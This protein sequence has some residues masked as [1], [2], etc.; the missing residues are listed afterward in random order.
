MIIKYFVNVLYIM[1]KIKEE[2]IKLIVDTYYNVESGLSS[3]Q[4]IYNKLN[5]K[6]PLSK[7]KI[8]LN[9]IEQYQTK[10][11]DNNYKQKFIPIVNQPG[12]YQCDLTFYS[13]IEKFNNGYHIL[14]TIININ[15]KYAYVYPM[16]NKNSDTVLKVF[17]QF[18]NNDVKDKVVN[19]ESDLG[20]EFI[21]KKFQDLLNENNIKLYLIDKNIS[22]NGTAIIERFNGTIRN[23][24]DKYLKAYKTNKFI[25]VLDK[26]VKNYNSSISQA[27]G[28]APKDVDEKIEQDLYIQKSILKL[29]VLNQVNNE[30]KIGDY[31]R[32]L[33]KKQLF[34]KGDEQYYS[35]SIFEITGKEFNKFIIKNID[36]GKTKFALPY[37][38]QI[39]NKDE[40]IKNPYLQKNDKQIEKDKKDLK[41]VKA[42]NK[43]KR[44][45]K[46]EG[47]YEEV[48]K[49]EKEK[50]LNK[51]LKRQGLDPNL[52]IKK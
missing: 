36:N 10:K 9:N 22:A 27:T 18:L 42:E 3:V 44:T 29:N 48:Q 8:V 47:I 32:I 4:D 11:K 21:S 16:K 26:L 34:S 40:I 24:I 2:D 43:Q 49:Q 12:T 13:Q 39:I 35:K 37:Q 33:K 31:C 6:I 50:K 5:K 19:I 1:E 45:L 23:K 14:L 20:S 30:I 7:I 15:S 25:D 51:K 28:Y 52:I 41:N 17:K 38:I 46:R